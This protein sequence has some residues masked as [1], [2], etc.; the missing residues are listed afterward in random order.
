MLPE[1]TNSKTKE[2]FDYVKLQKGL[3]STIVNNVKLVITG[4]STVTQHKIDYLKN[5]VMA[6]NQIAHVISATTFHVEKDKRQEAEGIALEYRDM[7]GKVTTD[8]KTIIGWSI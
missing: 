6:L 4:E 8:V 5:D 7:A 1:I 2:F 3:A